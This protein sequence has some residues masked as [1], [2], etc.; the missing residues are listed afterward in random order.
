MKKF[1]YILPVILLAA[2]CAKEPAEAEPE[3]NKVPLNITIDTK[4]GG[5]DSSDESLDISTIRVVVYENKG[6]AS[7]DKLIL[8]EYFPYG[9]DASKP[10]GSTSAID[11][12]VKVKSTLELSL[13]CDDY[14]VYVVLN[15]DG[16]TLKGQTTGSTLASALNS[17][18][19][20]DEMET[21]LATPA[22]YDDNGVTEAPFCLMSA[23]KT[24]Q[25][26]ANKDLPMDVKFSISNTPADPLKRNMAQITVGSIMSV[27]D[28]LASHSEATS[29][30]PQIFVLDV[31][32]VN[33]PKDMTWSDAEGST[34][35]GK[36]DL[37]ISSATSK[38]T[39]NDGTGASVFYYPR[40]WIGSVYRNIDVTMNRL[41]ET[42]A[43]LYR[44]DKA[45]TT[46]WGFTNPY[47]YKTPSVAPTEPSK[48]YGFPAQQGNKWKYRKGKYDKNR[49]WQKNEDSEQN[50]YDAAI[51]DYLANLPHDADNGNVPLDMVVV[52]AYV[53][54]M[55]EL[56]Y[57]N[58]AP[59]S[60]YTAANAGLKLVDATDIV[61]KL[62]TLFNSTDHDFW[63]NVKTTSEIVSMAETQDGPT[64]CSTDAWSISLDKSYYVP[65]NI[66]ASLDNTKT[67]CIK[68]TL[69]LADPK[70]DVSGITGDLI[71][72]LPAP[73]ADAATGGT[74]SYWMSNSYV[75]KDN[76]GKWTVNE[77]EEF[78]LSNLS[79]KL[80]INTYNNKGEINGFIKNDQGKTDDNFNNAFPVTPERLFKYK[81]HIVNADDQMVEYAK[82][83]AGNDIPD[84]NNYY[85]YVSGFYRKLN[86]LTGVSVINQKQ[87]GSSFAWNIPSSGTH[88]KTFYIPVNNN[89]GGTGYSIFRNTKYT[90]DLTVTYN[91]YEATKASA[92]EDDFGYGISATVTTEK[93]T[94][95][96]D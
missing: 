47:L 45:S 87:A 93:M 78:D 85:D 90:V 36:I 41:D 31:Q 7:T 86:G 56:N 15:E 69:A 26:G 73:D 14:Y 20:R 21:L 59:Q 13:G 80:H 6:T 66:S 79:G 12:T 32:L 92:S 11:Y 9:F 18:G 91:T 34:D 75:N 68:V 84:V 72:S 49:V 8:N 42:S 83:L 23:W 77:T 16:Y 54:Y 3:I 44:T 64:Y 50:N 55:D 89:I 48:P 74:A 43:K 63:E 37:P 29:K 57:Y 67:T 60:S 96:E 30:L 95:Y 33:V 39:H 81:G 25:F 28:T 22:V 38:D 58:G 94:D 4:A 40:N 65:E 10:D 27:P 2:A 70:L 71:Y 19:N 76:K 46:G 5:N 17:L 35:G 51:A 53:Q 1:L 88:V 61:S 82:D 52:N 24:I 62:S